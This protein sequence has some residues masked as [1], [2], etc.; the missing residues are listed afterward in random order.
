MHV[1]IMRIVLRL[2]ALG[3]AGANMRLEQ[4]IGAIDAAP[5][6]GASRSPYD[7]SGCHPRSAPPA[8]QGDALI[9]LEIFHRSE[10][11]LGDGDEGRSGE[12][13]QPIDVGHGSPGID[14]SCG[15]SRERR[16]LEAG[17]GSKSSG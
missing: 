6:R 2:E 16:E 13:L 14:R 3:Q 8:R 1:P 4:E 11:R 15:C 5:I 10:G 17:A 9:E 12:A 7:G